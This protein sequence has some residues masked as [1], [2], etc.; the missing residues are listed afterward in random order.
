MRAVTPCCGP[1]K[2]SP[3]KWVCSTTQA[4]WQARLTA[5]ENRYTDLIDNDAEWNRTKCAKA[6]NQGL[7]LALNGQLQMP[8]WGLQ[9][10]RLSLT[11]QDPQNDITQQAWPRGPKSLAQAGLTQSLG[12]WD[13]GLQLRYSGGAQR[14]IQGIAR[15]HF[16]RPDRQPGADSSASIES[17]G[18]KTPPTKPTKSIYGYNMPQRGLFVGL[19]WAPAR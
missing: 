7:E 9:Q 17:C 6:N 13:A 2:P 12:Q 19:N 1:K 15:L 16:V 11:S 10:W 18:L 4:Q 14:R 8:G 5:F 3:R